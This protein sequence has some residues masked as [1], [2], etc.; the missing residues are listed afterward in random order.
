MVPPYDDKKKH[1]QIIRGPIMM[2]KS[3][4]V[5]RLIKITQKNRP[6]ALNAM[7]NLPALN[8]VWFLKSRKTSKKNSIYDKNR[9]KL[10]FLEGS[11]GF[12][13]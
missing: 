10:T 9:Q 12:L 8:K 3:K 7:Q 4:T 11:F 5:E 6:D 13:T 2:P 1:L